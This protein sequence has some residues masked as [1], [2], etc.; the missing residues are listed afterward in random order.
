MF[1]SHQ[2]A[3]VQYEDKTTAVTGGD[4]AYGQ[5]VTTDP[6]IGLPV[7]VLGDGGSGPARLVDTNPASFWSSQ[8]YYGALRFGGRQYAIGGP[9]VA[10]MHS[11]WVNLSRLYSPTPE[12]AQPAA[13]V[14]CCSGVDRE[15]LD[16]V[17]RRPGSGDRGTEEWLAVSGMPSRLPPRS[18]RETRKN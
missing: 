15:R 18:G 9:R 11:R 6:L 2:A 17:E 10:R 5:P 12:L 7:S 8:I 14:A 1:G 16:R 3:F 4:A 13:A